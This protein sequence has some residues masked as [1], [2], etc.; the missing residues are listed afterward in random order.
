[1]RISSAKAAAVTGLGVLPLIAFGACSSSS[2]THGGATSTTDSGTSD[3]GASPQGC[4]PGRTATAYL[5]GAASSTTAGAPADGGA[6]PEPCFVLTGEGSA[7][8]SIGIG[9]D[10][11]VFFAPAFG[12]DG[13][14]IVRSKDEGV[15]W[16]HLV[17]RF[18][19]GGGHGRTQPFMY[20]DPSTNRVFFATSVLG[21]PEAGASPTGFNLTVSSDE[22]ATWSYQAI[23]PDVRDWIKIYAGPPVSSQPDGYPNIVYA[24]APSPISTPDSIIYPQPDHQ[25]VYKS[26]NGGSTWQSANDGGA[27]G[28]TL[29]PTSEVE[30]GLA[31]ATTCPPTEWVIFGDGVVGSDGVIYLG[32]RMC[33]QLA[34]A[35]S[36]DEGSTW[37]TIVVPGSTLPSFKSILS[38]LTTNNL[39]QSE[40]VVVD[41]ANNLY[42]IW[43]DAAGLVR[44]SVSTD[45]GTTWNGG[46][47]PLVVSAPGLTSTVY[48]AMAVKSPGTLAIA[49]YG[50][51]DGKTYNGYIAESLDA[52]A[53]L[54]LFWS[55]AVNDPADPLFTMGFDPGYSEG[56]TAD[57]VEFVQVK[58]APSGDIWASFVKEMC[59]GE[60]TSACTWDYALHAN[61]V[62]Q[63]AVGRLVHP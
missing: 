24:S 51:A 48:S 19:G 32:L 27:G 25:S 42:A 46:A 57:L 40:P 4:Q 16:E 55:A 49:Y 23:A 54:P 12:P 61:S 8:S 30:A 44:L 14:G 3:M 38:P 21:N 59:P 17:P 6:A 10:G 58:Y 53:S 34:I 60:K 11:T 62:F 22:G 1:M 26:L 5:A 52:T 7:E 35:T 31:T 28:L 9:S 33:T 56:T 20:V 43:N 50:S 47:G 36:K 41:S 29:D 15:T 13:N 45:H 63:G 37:T 18:P 2:A 39:L